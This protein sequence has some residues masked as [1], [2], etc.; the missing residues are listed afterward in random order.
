MGKNINISVNIQT[1]YLVE[2][3]KKE[4]PRQLARH[5]LSITV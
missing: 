5:G 4:S 3:H 1:A 2:P